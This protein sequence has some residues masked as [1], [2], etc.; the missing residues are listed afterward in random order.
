LPIPIA[1][2]EPIIIPRVRNTPMK[3]PTCSL[4]SSG[5]LEGAFMAHYVEQYPLL[6]AKAIIL[7]ILNQSEFS[8]NNQD[9]FVWKPIKMKVTMKIALAHVD[10]ITKVSDPNAKG[11]PP[12]HLPKVSMRLKVKI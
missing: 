2:I 10:I 8:P 11:Y 6:A 7:I 3:F 1:K 9:G 12:S 5:A 4:L